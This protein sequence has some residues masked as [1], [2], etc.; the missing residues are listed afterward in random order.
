MYK[1]LVKMTPYMSVLDVLSASLSGFTSCLTSLCFCV[2]LEEDEDT[3]S[4]REE[5]RGEINKAEN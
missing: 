2:A 3:V 5:A 4:V 1:L